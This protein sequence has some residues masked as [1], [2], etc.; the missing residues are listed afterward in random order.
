LPDYPAVDTFKSFNCNDKSQQ[1]NLTQVARCF[2]FCKC[3]ENW[4]CH[5]LHK[6]R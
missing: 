2:L 6:L 1:Q 3:W 4:H 5:S